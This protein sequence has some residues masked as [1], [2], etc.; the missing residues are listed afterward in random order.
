[1]ENIVVEVC[2]RLDPA[3]FAV[4]VCCLDRLGPF[5]Q[6]LRAAVGRVEL[7]KAPGFRWRYVSEL[8]AL[9][10]EG[11]FDV[12]HTHHR[13]GLIYAA[14]A[15]LG[16]GGPRGVRSAYIILHGAEVDR[17]RLWQRKLLYRKAASCGFAVSKQQMEQLR[18][19][20]LNHRKIFALP[21]GV[22]C[23]RFR[24]VAGE[25]ITILRKR[26]GS[27]NSDRCSSRRA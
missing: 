20:G 15:R 18:V 24:P 4:T 5:A 14:L 21:N 13:G 10:R 26:L 7:C 12:V 19:L 2:N 1:M 11:A 6:R 23:G 3:R 22:D 8:R 17:R 25:E 16:L 27:R 9:M